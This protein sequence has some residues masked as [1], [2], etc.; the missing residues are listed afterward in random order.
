VTITRFL[1]ALGSNRRGR[2]GGPAAE[3]RAALA[4]L[5]PVARS[6]LIETPPLGPSIRR[7]VN[8]AALIE[9]AESPPAL[10]ARLKRIEAA[11]GRRRGQRWGARVIDL[12]IVLWSAGRWRSPGLII[13]HPLFRDRAFVLGPAERL[14]PGWRDPVTA[15]TMRQLSRRLT[16]ACALPRSPG[17]AGL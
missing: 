11:F 5:E 8:A 3:V 4:L 9:T 16:R 17:R 12:D 6:P 10:L 15:L 7:F 2:N 14:A 1:V 13:P